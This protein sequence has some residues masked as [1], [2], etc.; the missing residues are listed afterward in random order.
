MTARS[1]FAK[2]L[3]EHTALY[4]RNLAKVIEGADYENN[5]EFADMIGFVLERTDITDVQMGDFLS[6]GAGTIGRW[7]SSKVS[8]HSI[9]RDTARTRIANELRERADA[10]DWL[11]KIEEGYS[12]T[13]THLRAVADHIRLRPLGNESDFAAMISFATS[14][15]GIE[16]PALADA[17]GVTVDAVSRWRKGQ[18]SPQV[19]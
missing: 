11:C 5:A 2:Q 6:V 8:P 9:M 17:F 4:W 10:L 13:P 3:I 19:F 1:P 7:A 12:A 16:P 15:C 14:C 18:S